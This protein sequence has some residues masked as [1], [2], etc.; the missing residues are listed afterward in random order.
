MTVLKLTKTSP[1][2]KV[3]TNIVTGFLGSGKSTLIR[4][5]I[6][7]KNNDEHWVVLINEFGDVG[8]DDQI[9]ESNLT[10]GSSKKGQI[11]ISQIAGGCLCCA[12][13]VP[14]QVALVQLLKQ[15]NKSPDRL[16]IEPT[17]L[18]HPKQI[19]NQLAI[20]PYI[21]LQ[22]V[23]TV[24]DPRKVKDARYAEH[25]LFT[26]QI[27]V[28]NVVV[29]NKQDVFEY[30][31][32]ALFKNWMIQKNIVSELIVQT[33]RGRIDQELLSKFKP[34]LNI[35][36]PK[37]NLLLNTTGLKSQDD[38]ID[39][40]D[41]QPN[42]T[43]KA[44]QTFEQNIEGFFAVGLIFDQSFMFDENILFNELLGLEV[45]RIKAVVK[46]QN[47]TLIIN[48]VDSVISQNYSEDEITESRFQL[49]SNQ[50]ICVI[51]LEALILSA[52]N[53]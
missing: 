15:Q 41:F 29:C 32:V 33:Q 2:N 40:M 35:T 12:N 1:I 23:F 21:N 37:L 18:G 52:A 8:L 24:V 4:S 26:T 47:K 39:F 34:Q 46:I 7:H 27:S 14:F 50:P 42:Q 30:A 16:I 28:A 13:G 9:I 36:Q 51:N 11:Q 25:E 44:I 17:G 3:P 45:I 31:D 20:L 38:S 48:G 43:K 19:I 5:L 53:S 22:T 10:D 6:T 49:I